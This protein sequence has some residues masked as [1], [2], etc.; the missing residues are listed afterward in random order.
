MKTFFV[1]IWRLIFPIKNENQ[2]VNTDVIIEPI[3][4]TEKLEIAT[5]PVEAPVEKEVTTKKTPAKKAPVKKAPIKK[6]AAQ[7]AP[8]KKITNKKNK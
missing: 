2:V 8:A 3:E 5:T 1:K 6:A 7:K 4:I